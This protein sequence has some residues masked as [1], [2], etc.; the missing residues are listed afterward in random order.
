METAIE[1]SDLH[2]SYGSI[3]AVNGISLTVSRGEVLG[4][5]GANGAGKSTTIECILGIRRP[6]SG[7][8]SILNMAP[9]KERK[10]LFEKVGVQF[11]EISY[12]DKIKVSELCQVTSSFYKNPAEYA[13]LLNQFGLNDKQHSYVAELSGGQKQ[14]LFIVLSLIPK[15]DVVF[16]D[17]LTTGLDPKA[18]RMV[19]KSLTDLKKGGSLSCLHPIFVMKLKFCVI[20]S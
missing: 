18:R 2:K 13:E 19:W 6:D 14:R 3:K 20:G 9:Y 10:K 1:V 15:P 12:Q 7:K 17:E 11:Q 4:L 8:I 16:L 5:L